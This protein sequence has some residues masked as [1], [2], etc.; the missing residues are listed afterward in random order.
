VRRETN[1]DHTRARAKASSM[2]SD[3]ESYLMNS[4]LAW[5]LIPSSD[6]WH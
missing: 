1:L 2:P 3:D 6:I 4:E 5:A